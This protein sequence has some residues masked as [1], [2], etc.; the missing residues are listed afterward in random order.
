MRA[1]VIRGRTKKG[2]HN[3]AIRPVLRY[4]RESWTLAKKS[5]SALY[6]FERKVLRRMMC[7]MKENDTWRIR[8]NNELYI[9]FK[10]PRHIKYY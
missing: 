6:A 8:Y 3:A 7:S 2:L 10:E 4:P 9:Q 5:E 1:R